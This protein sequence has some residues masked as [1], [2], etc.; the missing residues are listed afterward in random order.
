MFT[1]IQWGD[2]QLT[3]DCGNDSVCSALSQWIQFPEPVSVPAHPSHS[4]LGAT[5]FGLKEQ[6]TDYAANYITLKDEFVT[7]KANYDTHTFENMV[8]ALRKELT[9]KIGEALNSN[10]E[11]ARD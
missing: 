11:C 1:N 8:S 9:N 4:E 10:G 5:I 2:Y 7:F 3:I 6:L